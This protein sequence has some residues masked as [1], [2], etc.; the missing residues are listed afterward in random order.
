[1]EKNSS[2]LSSE[3]AKSSKGKKP[4]NSVNSSCGTFLVFLA[5]LFWS[6]GGLFVRNINCPSLALC[7]LRGLIGF[8]TMIVFGHKFPVFF[9][10]NPD[11]SLNKSETVYLW[12]GGLC[13]F[14]TSTLY[15]FANKMTTAAN[16]ILLQYTNPIWIILFGPVFLGEKNTKI[17][18][19]TVAG[20]FVGML[21]FFADE[22]AGGLGNLNKT[23]MIGN[24]LAVL[25][26]VTMGFTTIFLRKQKSG[27]S[28]E[29][30]M[31]SQLLGF[32]IFLPAVFSN[33]LPD[34]RSCVFIVLLGI[35]V[36]GLPGIF[37][38]TGLRTVSA[39]T[40]SLVAMTEPLMN[41]IWVFI[42]MGEIPGKFCIAGGIVI[43]GFVVFRIM[44]S[45]MKAKR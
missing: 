23:V 30:Y 39:L 34:G 14:A 40:A 31:I 21:M 10:K 24:L 29:S 42:F 26:G 44:F 25:S 1:M 38:A 43:V 27:K 15:I 16:A 22:F 13:Y 35:V 20:V 3:L 18:Y 11:N 36:G 5:A 2:V 37:Y 12:L 32:V 6:C 28:V 8:F 9:I 41:P 4:G 17:D 19:L 7:S 45:S 33:G